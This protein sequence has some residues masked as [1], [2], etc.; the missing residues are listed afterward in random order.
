MTALQIRD[1]TV[2]TAQG[3]ELLC[4]VD[5]DVDPGERVSLAGNTGNSTGP[6]LHFEVRI[7]GEPVDPLP[8]LEDHGIDLS[9]NE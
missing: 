2:R 4:G 5:L 9:N 7:H 3:R 6:H 8:W 1:L